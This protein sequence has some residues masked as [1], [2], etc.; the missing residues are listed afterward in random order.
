MIK[1]RAMKISIKRPRAIVIIG[2]VLA[3]VIGYFVIRPKGSQKLPINL[4]T[5]K[6]VK[7]VK[8]NIR[9]DLVLAGKIDAGAYANLEFQTAGKLA[10][11]GVKEGDSVKKGQAIASL[12][13][14]LLKKQLDTQMNNY[15]T[16]R[17]TFEDVQDQYKEVRDRFLVTTAIQ[18]NL[19]RTQFSLNNAVL[20]VEIIAKQ[21][22]DATII[23]PIAGI[24]TNVE[25]PVAGV[26]IVPSTTTFTVIDPKSVY[27]RAEI[28][29]TDVPTVKVGQNT[30]I[31]IDSYPDN[32]IETKISTISFTP[33]MGETS[34]VYK[35]NFNLPENNDLKYRL[36]MNGDANIKIAEADNVLYLPIEAI[37]SEN[38]NSF[39]YIKNPKTKKAEKITVKTGLENDNYVEIIE[40]LSEGTEVLVSSS[41]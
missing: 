41:S 33:V 10:W 37:Y 6:P 31:N 38:N 22:S 23:S 17:W 9:K 34:T 8:G 36:G 20:S 39:V 27:F 2:I 35:I 16:N 13:T 19:D 40:G 32:P 3:L 12:D 1:Y 5:A 18:R 30:T 11:V 7:V 28:D 25:Q 29:E 15:L 21:V 4:K 24:I 26:N 14:T